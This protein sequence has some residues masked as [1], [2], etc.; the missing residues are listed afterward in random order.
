MT[1][2][3]NT[4]PQPDLP[5]PD[6]SHGRSF[7]LVW[8]IPIIT[9][10][11]GGWL[12]VKTL[13]E[14]GP[15]ATISFKTADGIEAGK[16]KIKFKNVEIGVVESVQFAEDFSHVILS[17]E[18]HYG[19]K[20]FLR[21]DS[22]FWV[23]KPRLGL[24]GV[25]GLDTLISGAYI[26]IEPGQG[27]AR[28]HFVGL[29]TPPVV[30]ASENGKE[31]V[32]IADKLGSI[33]TG[34]PIY[35]QGI[36]AGE[37]LGYELGNDRKSVYIHAFIKSPLDELI[38]SNTRFWN[39]S[40]MDVSLGADGFQMRTESM[41]T[42]LFGGIAFETPTTNEPMQ[43]G[44]DTLIFTL[45][46]SYDAIQDHAFTQKLKFVMFFDSSVR[47][48]SV[49][50][51]VEFKGIKVGSVLD[52][53]LEFDSND[54]SFRIPVIIEIEPE[55]IVDRNA[56]KDRASPYET[57]SNLVNKGLRAQL[58]TGSLLTGQLYVQLD[59]RPDTVATLSG[60][61]NV[62]PELPTVPGGMDAITA[63]L[64]NF[65]SKLEKVEIDKIGK[66]L[67]TTLEGTGKLFS[68]PELHAA[69]NDL[70]A[71]LHSLKAILDELDGNNINEAIASA[72]KVLEKT[73]TT[74]TL[75]NSALKPDSPIQ[76][77][78]IQMTNEL[79]ETAR[80]IRSLVDLLERNPESLIFGKE[81]K[82]E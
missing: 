36:T 54:S 43:D 46:D 56:D 72:R 17:A 47:G 16:T 75:L 9:L 29:E 45:Y 12:T 44:T 41:Q 63:S 53:R 25:S 4:S 60:E 23:V 35:Y 18:F 24:R 65:A 50:A 37:V 68:S 73:E 76:H 28:R 20:S 77:S 49:G 5:E 21:R 40:G 58:A 61:E 34:S 31:I 2:S 22:R 79:E 1:E 27:I 42:L 38:Q 10:L 66:E 62:L 55:R 59:M 33:D 74:M 78:V 67:L 13:S 32:I 82:G 69:A 51:P 57:L 11:I 19:T 14:Q 70:K 26:E 80:S 3:D 30:N 64:Q 81:I 71:T 15:K 8:L 48:L 39:V 52:V 7:S 6:I